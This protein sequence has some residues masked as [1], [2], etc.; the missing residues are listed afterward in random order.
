MQLLTFK[1]KSEKKIVLSEK[2]VILEPGDKTTI[3]AVLKNQIKLS[4]IRNLH[5]SQQKHRLQ[6]FHQKEKSL[7]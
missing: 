3:D 4:G 5:I 6:R 7:Q 2:K 1:L